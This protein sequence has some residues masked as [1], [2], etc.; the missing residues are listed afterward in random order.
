MMQLR[1][2]SIRRAVAGIVA[3]ALV[4]VLASAPAPARAATHTRNA[5][6]VPVLRWTDCGDGFQ[7]TTARVPLDYDRPT[8]RPSSSRSCAGRPTTRPQKIGSVFIN[9]G[10]PGGSGIEFVAGFGHELFSEEV[11]ARFDI[12]GFDPRGVGQSTPLRCFRT[13][14]EV[15]EAIAPYAFPVTAG[16]G[17]RVD[18]RRPPRRPRLRRPAPADPRSHEHGQRCA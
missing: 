14:A 18:R 3:A 16:R 6:P 4:A 5:A 15:F 2:R 17:R 8:G 1:R 12:I 13:E 7:C 10:G 11:R 9:P